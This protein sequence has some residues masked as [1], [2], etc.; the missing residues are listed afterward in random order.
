LAQAAA[1]M[2]ETGTSPA[3]Y[4]RLLDEQVQ[5]LMRRGTPPDYPRS[6]AAATDVVMQRLEV[7]DAAAA[8]LASV[9]AWLAPEPIRIAWFT[10]AAG[11]SAKA[12]G[13]ELPEPL[14]GAA[15]SPVEFSES[16]SRLVRYGI[17][18]ST[19]SGFVIHRLT[20]AV[21]RGRLTP[22]QQAACRAGVE[23][24]VVAVA[25][26]GAGGPGTWPTWVAV[27][28]H[29]IALDP[30][31]SDNP[32]VRRA[33]WDG[34]WE[35]AASG[36]LVA[37]AELARHLHTA[38][39]QRLGPDHLDTQ[40]AA[41]TLAEALRN[42][43]DYRGARE[44]N[45]E[46]L[47][48]HRRV[49]GADHPETLAS[50]SNLAIAL[51]ALGEVTAARESDEDTVARMRRVLGQDHPATLLSAN[52]LAINLHVMGEVAASREL[53][54]DTLARY[55]RVLG[56]D[57][58]D[59][60]R[61]ANNL[62]GDLRAL[63]EVAAARELDEETLARKQRVLG[64]DHP[65]TLVS[66]NNL[67]DDLRAL[68]EHEAARALDEDTLARRRRVLGEDHPHTQTSAN[69]L[70]ADLRALEAA[71]PPGRAPRRPWRRRRGS[72]A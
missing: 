58:P 29:L 48:R 11:D 15:E 66:A 19:A 2:S 31:N 46:T 60:L 39:R 36:N 44:L 69:N 71:E 70:A 62:A 10:T 61:T 24:V 30:A 57:H 63:G 56:E 20:A 47:A 35:L 41:T 53:N 7:E 16:V 17:A 72:G 51:R 54:E 13:G 64:E 12:D 28:P 67:A 32:A 8:Q 1:F 50:A 37:G 59:T 65:D 21:L 5:E 6:L 49:L 18:R 40:H 38:W 43:G 42:L 4:V 33:G 55:R 45:E 14:A 68:G 9:A 34:A 27:M 26:V 52:N 3:E 23:T 25:P 22:Q